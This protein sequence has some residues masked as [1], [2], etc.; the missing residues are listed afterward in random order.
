[1]E[2]DPGERLS[3]YLCGADGE[4]LNAE[5]FSLDEYLADIPEEFFCSAAG[6]RELTRDDPLLFAVVYVPDLLKESPDGQ[7]TFGD[8]H[9]GLY[10]DALAM[11]SVAGVEGDRRSY[12]APR[13]SGKS[14]TLF[15][16]TTLWLA[17]H[18]PCFVSAFSS[19]ATQAHDHLK[20]VRSKLASTDL[21]RA[22]FPEATSPALK[23]SGTPVSDSDQ[24]VFM[25]NGFCFTARGIDTEVLGLVDPLNRRPAVIYLDDIEG[26]E[27][28]GYSA[29]QAEQR[30][31]TLIDGILPMNDRA[32]VR[33]VGTVTIPGGIMHQLVSTVTTTDPPAGWITE[34]RFRVTYFPP[35]VYRGDGTPRSCWPGKWRIDHLLAISGTRS[36]AKNFANQPTEV[37]G[38][39]WT[40]DDITY[41]TLDTLT[42]RILAIDPAVTTKRSS[43]RTGIAVVAFS[44]TARCVVVEHAEGVS[45]T[46]RRLADHLLG[47]VRSWPTRIHAAVIEVNQGGD[48][49]PEVLDQLPVKVITKSASVSKEVRFAAALEWYQKRPESWVLHADKFH[50]L[51][52]EMVGF[53]RAPHDDIVDATMA[54]VEYFLGRG[55]QKIPVRGRAVAY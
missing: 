51:E 41:G 19:S 49:W 21:L 33:L 26:A 39:Y 48:L 1:V 32:H 16:I 13:G 23:P 22:D 35:I 42:R 17:C 55:E 38:G 12:V 54:G 5:T 18:Y 36:F 8:V 28:S 31:R 24:M 44:P 34:E 45:L 10:R 15:V 53:P 14:T 9:L 50:A 30:L 7:I 47:L 3:G 2:G 52:A 20:A 6:R 46:G 25:R 40:G 4:P 43:D 27:G 37:D 11:R 29:Y